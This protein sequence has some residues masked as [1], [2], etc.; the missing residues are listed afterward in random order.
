MAIDHQG[1]AF[2]VE[3]EVYCRRRSGNFWRMRASL[4]LACA[5][6][7]TLG[8]QVIGR[9]R[10]RPPLFYFFDL[11]TCACSFEVTVTSVSLA[12]CVSHR[13]LFN[14]HKPSSL[15]HHLVN[16]LV[17]SIQTVSLFIQNHR[18]S[19]FKPS[20]SFNVLSN[21]RSLRSL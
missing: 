18:L 9:T 2:D 14:T 15:S 5:Q 6:A 19:S 4:G 21:H 20:S 16:T 13:G 17:F 3:S 10:N 8:T 1:G 7:A 11:S 12:P